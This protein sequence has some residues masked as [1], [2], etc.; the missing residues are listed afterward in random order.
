MPEQA[1]EQRSDIWIWALVIAATASV[2]A[3]AIRQGNQSENFAGKSAPEV[4]LPLLGGGKAAIERGKVTLVDFWAT[5]CGP[6]RVSMP[7]VQKVWQDY[8]PK[9]VALYS[10][11]T[12]DPTADRES[13]VSEFLLQNRLTFPV[14]LDDGSAERAF[15]IASLPTMLL[16]DKEGRVAWSHIGALN[17]TRETDLRAALDRALAGR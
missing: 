7:R 12:D 3:L 17:A 1:V 2:V 6:C 8:T 9:G 10:V 15:S 11:D 13:Q 14:V 4:S 5:W 16:L